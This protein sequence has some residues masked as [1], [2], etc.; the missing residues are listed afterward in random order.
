VEVHRTKR[1][2]RRESWT[3]RGIE[4]GARQMLADKVSG[5]MVGLWMLIPE[6]L[7]LGT[8]DLLR[9]WAGKPTDALEPRLAMQLVHEATLC[10]TGVR[11]QRSCNHRG[12]ELANG[13]PFVAT[14]TQIHKLLDAHTVEQAQQLQVALGKVRRASGHFCGAERSWRS[15]RTGF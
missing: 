6:H 5:T 2:A 7:R 4:R 1:Q 14:D 11:A 13:L 3:L 15:T 8:W 9:G 10:C 12:F